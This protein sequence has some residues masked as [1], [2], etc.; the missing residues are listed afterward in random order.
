MGTLIFGSDG[1]WW[2]IFW[3][4]FPN[5]ST[6]KL[7]QNIFITLLLLY[8]EI[9]AKMVCIPVMPRNIFKNNKTYTDSVLMFLLKES[10]S[11]EKIT[12]DSGLPA[13]KSRSHGLSNCCET[14]SWIRDGI[15]SSRIINKRGY[16]CSPLEV[17]EFEKSSLLRWFCSK[18]IL[19]QP[20]S[21]C[22]V[23]CLLF[24][25]RRIFYLR[26]N[27]KFVHHHR[28]RHTGTGVDGNTREGR[29]AFQQ[30]WVKHLSNWKKKKEIPFG[31]QSG[32]PTG[33]PE[34]RKIYSIKLKYFTYV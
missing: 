29:T 10:S 30:R 14:P 23:S 1:K 2:K 13:K 24:C 27:L 15:K 9:P 11:V 28:A 17:M 5:A 3:L 33:C 16:L 12:K 19:T 7:I 26:T 21:L 6:R 8:Q 34:T 32:S 25:L 20:A 18:G 31:T 22:T 4:D